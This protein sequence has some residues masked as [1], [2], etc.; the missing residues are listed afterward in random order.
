MAA[1]PAIRQPAR[2]GVLAT[3]TEPER[4]G[5]GAASRT[6]RTALRRSVDTS[7]MNFD[8]KTAY[9]STRV[10]VFARNIVST[11]HPLGAQAGLRIIPAG[12]QCGRRRDR[13]R[14]RDDDRRAVQQ[15]PRLRRVLHPLGRR[16]PARPQRLR[17]GAGGMDAGVLPQASTAP[18]RT[19]RR[20]AA[21]I[22]SPCPARSPVGRALG[23]LRHACR[24]PTC[25][26]PRSRSP[27]AAMRCRWSCS[28]SGSRRRRCL[29]RCPAG[30]TPSCRMAGPPEIGE[31]FA[32]AAAAPAAARDRLDARRRAVRRRDRRR[33]GR[34]RAA[35]TAA[36]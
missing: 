5:P 14:R 27:N 6:Q 3:A 7:G 2:G 11:S 34:A 33:G 13:R 16:A 31:R 21:G 17:P 8:W 35:S 23:A 20:S 29:A 28:R 19:G 9:P 12:R 22:R 1:L 4:P 36:P 32:F 10:P 15:R 30:P 25:S 18:A 26:R 24:S